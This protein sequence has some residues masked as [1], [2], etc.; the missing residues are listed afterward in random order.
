[1]LEKSPPRHLMPKCHCSTSPG[2]VWLFILLD[3]YAAGLASPVP[4][5]PGSG[6]SGALM[7]LI[8]LLLLIRASGCAR[9][10]GQHL[11]LQAA[12]QAI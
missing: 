2:T 3:Y 12:D 8:F 10:L 4:L 9:R 6:A 5:A 1:M 11:V 7:S